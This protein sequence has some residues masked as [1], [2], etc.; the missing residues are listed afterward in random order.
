MH[1]CFGSASFSSRHWWSSIWWFANFSRQALRIDGP[2]R[3]AGFARASACNADTTCQVDLTRTNVP[4]APGTF[5]RRHDVSCMLNLH[6]QAWSAVD[7]GPVGGDGASNRSSQTPTRQLVQPN[8]RTLNIVTVPQQFSPTS[9]LPVRTTPRTH[10][11]P[12]PMPKPRRH[13]LAVPT[14]GKLP[15]EGAAHGRRFIH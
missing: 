9:R 8:R 10:G 11:P 5:R 7:S 3:N 6:A 1:A 4:N 14:I 15:A 13:W 12:T 2:R